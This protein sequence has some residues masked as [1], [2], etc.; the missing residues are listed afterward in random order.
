MSMQQHLHIDDLLNPHN[1]FAVCSILATHSSE[2]IDRIA[3]HRD[4][5]TLVQLFPTQDT[6]WDECYRKLHDLAQS[7]GGDFFSKQRVDWG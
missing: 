1:R 3:I 4:I 7:D 5:T 2:N 6:A